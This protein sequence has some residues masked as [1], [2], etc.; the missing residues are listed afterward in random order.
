[1][2]RLPVCR[3]ATNAL[4][5]VSEN[6]MKICGYSVS[7]IL[8]LP[9]LLQV[10]PRKERSAFHRKALAVRS[11]FQ[12]TH[13]SAEPEV[14]AT[15]LRDPEGILLPMWCA[16]HF[17]GGKHKLLVC[18]FEPDM[19][20]DMGPPSSD[21]PSSPVNT[22][23]NQHL[24]ATCFLSASEPLNFGPETTD[25]F[26][27]E[28]KTMDAI[29]IMSRIQEQLS[30]AAEVQRLLDVIVGITK[31]LTGSH[32]CMVYRYDSDWHGQSMLLQSILPLM[33][34][35]LTRS[36]AYSP[37]GTC[38]PQSQCRSLQGHALSRIGYA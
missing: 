22:L 21:L 29:H 12:R 3:R 31:E 37:F 8:S 16:M 5:V 15:N 34:F 25:I 18:E 38:R 1:M 9:T 30:S 28:S 11:R 27:G 32:R 10:L 6:A 35:F 36:V 17:V 14:F 23:Q 19:S 20:P 24:D 4:Q 2:P 26:R 13:V 33:C 7:D